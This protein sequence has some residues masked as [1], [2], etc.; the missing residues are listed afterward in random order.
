MTGKKEGSQQLSTTA[1]TQVNTDPGFRLTMVWLVSSAFEDKGF[2]SLLS[3]DPDFDPGE[4]VDIEP[5]ASVWLSDEE[6]ALVQLRVRISPRKQPTFTLDVCY[7]AQYVV[8]GS[9]IMPL[10]EF[11]W[12]NGLAN[13]VP[14][15]RARVA[16][17]TNDSRFPALYLQPINLAALQLQRNAIADYNA[18]SL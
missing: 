14:F 10:E 8:V 3:G 13:L 11:A 1:E 9:A 7:A 18:T 5:T 16:M 6:S 17:I 15:I 2:E 4:D 12:T